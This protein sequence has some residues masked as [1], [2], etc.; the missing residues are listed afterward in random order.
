MFKVLI[1]VDGSSNALKAVQHVINDC[2]NSGMREVHL[3]NVRT[4]LTQHAARFIS[5]RD[6][7]AYHRAEAEKALT[8]ARALL[9]RFGVPFSA[10]TELGDKAEVID[11]VAQRL[12]VD[13]IVMGTARKNSFT[14]LI[15]DSV[16]N[17]VIELTRVPVAIVPGDSVSQLE[18]IG[19]PAGIGAI[20]ALLFAA[21]E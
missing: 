15:E 9:E 12:R 4:P 7:A 21:A 6:R 5:K 13:Q 2:I 16:S 17:R 14:R 10:H 8:P 3:L 1:P 20:V 18:R 11:R 19:V